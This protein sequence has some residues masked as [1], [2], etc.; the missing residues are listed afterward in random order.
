MKRGGVLC[1]EMAFTR[2][3]YGNQDAKQEIKFSHQD[4]LA[5]SHCIMTKVEMGKDIQLKI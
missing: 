3:F 4:S 5:R 2:T 1:V